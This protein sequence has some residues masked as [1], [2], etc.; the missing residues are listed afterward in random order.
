MKGST[1]LRLE[2]KASLS[3]A[4]SAA[5]SLSTITD[6]ISHWLLEVETLTGL[7]A[8]RPLF[9]PCEDFP[10]AFCDYRSVNAD[11]DLERTDI[12][13]PNIK[14]ESFSVYHNPTH[15]WYFMSKMMPNEV[16]LLKQADTKS[17][18]A[19]CKAACAI[20][21]FK[22]LTYT[23]LPSCGHKR[24]YCSRKHPNAREY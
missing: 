5:R 13:Y 4:S 7:S 12:V 18:T 22:R 6:G 9:G 19:S 24:S 17:G 23:R 20:T 11:A 21:V 3:Q 8:W 16:V 10:L 2:L 15:K 14:S 1:R